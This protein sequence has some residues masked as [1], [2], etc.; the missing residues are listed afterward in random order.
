LREVPGVAA[1]HEP[2]PQ[3]VEMMRP[4][5]KDPRLAYQFLHHVKLP[6]LAQIKEPVYVE[7]SHLACKGFIEPMLL[8]GLRP[9]LIV[10]RRRPREVAL[11]YLARNTVPARTE[12]GINY[13]LDPRDPYVLPLLEWEQASDY[14]LCFWYAL[15]I[16]RRQR[17]YAAMTAE[18]GLPVVDVT[19]RELNDWSV[20]Q[21]LLA[22]L[23]GLTATDAVRQAHARISG[24]HHNPSTVQ[25]EPPEGIELAEE[26]IWQRIGFYEP[27][28]RSH[29][30]RR[31]GL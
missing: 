4:A 24:Q 5:Q 18:L 16:E 27:L 30:E 10:L 15:E 19:H 25:I 12:L 23:G 31:Y 26:A 7:T 6:F 17:R 9:A 28:L 20:F 14:Q 22:Q 21:G 11:S 1:F 8:M 29:V 2:F 13:L 3:F